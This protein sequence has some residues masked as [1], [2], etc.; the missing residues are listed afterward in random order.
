MPML[1]SIITLLMAMFMA[2]LSMLMLIMMAMMEELILKISDSYQSG[3]IRYDT[4]SMFM[5]L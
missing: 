2:M 5:S 3:Y 1:M 4:L